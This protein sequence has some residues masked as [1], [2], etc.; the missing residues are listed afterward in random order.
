MKYAPEHGKKTVQTTLTEKKSIIHLDFS[1]FE[2]GRNT[3]NE[4]IEDRRLFKD[5]AGMRSQGD[6]TVR[7]TMLKNNFTI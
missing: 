2:V 5:V 6:A 7:Q 3:S 1:R 4:S